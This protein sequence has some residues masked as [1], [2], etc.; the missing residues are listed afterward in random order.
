[1]S[2]LRINPLVLIEATYL[3]VELSRLIFEKARPEPKT[4]QYALG[5]KNMTLDGRPCVLTPGPLA[6]FAWEF[7]TDFQQPPQPDISVSV[8]WND[9]Q[10]KLGRVAFLLVREVY[11]WFG[12][13][14]EAIPYKEREGD[15]FVLSPEQI[16]KAGS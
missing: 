11:R 10:I 3:F 6:G 13:E 16:R 1:M 15:E 5:L 9:P 14:D 2:F 4:I 7:G 8:I 12:I